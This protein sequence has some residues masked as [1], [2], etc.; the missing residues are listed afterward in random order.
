MTDETYWDRLSDEYAAHTPDIIGET[1][2]PQGPIT[3]DDVIGFLAG[4]RPRT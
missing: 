3:M 2:H 4:R 1:V